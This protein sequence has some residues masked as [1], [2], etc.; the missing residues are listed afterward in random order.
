MNE[1]DNA[2]DKLDSIA[3]S[4]VEIGAVWAKH[5]LAIGRSALEASAKTLNSTATALGQ[6]A[7][8]LEAKNER[9]AEA[10]GATST[11]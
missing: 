2:K 5:G 7:D 4:L 3:Q 9:A 8:S 10:S 6:I 11:S 1:N